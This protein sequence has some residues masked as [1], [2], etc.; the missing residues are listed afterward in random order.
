MSM[1]WP[2]YGIRIRPLT[3]MQPHRKNTME[4]L[5]TNLIQWQRKYRLGLSVSV[6]QVNQ[7]IGRSL[8]QI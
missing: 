4:A 3:N 2:H 6:E 1:L 5:F 7:P 8:K